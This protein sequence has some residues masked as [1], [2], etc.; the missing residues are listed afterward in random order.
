[1]RVIK[2]NSPSSLKEVVVG[3]VKRLKQNWDIGGTVMRSRMEVIITR[4][5]GR[6]LGTPAV[7]RS[8]QVAEGS[9]WNL[10]PRA[11]QWEDNPETSTNSQVKRHH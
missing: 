10:A 9:G 11:M 1:M 2:W 4:V 7:M 6:E 3:A 5:D 8:K